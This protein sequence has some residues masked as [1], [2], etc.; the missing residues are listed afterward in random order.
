MYG[1]AQAPMRKIL[2]LLTD[3]WEKTPWKVESDCEWVAPA[4]RE[5]PE[6]PGYVAISATNLRGPYLNDFSRHV[7]APLLKRRPVTVVGHCIYVYWA[8]EPWW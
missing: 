5:K 8:D 2:R 1:P 3:R 4:K 6:L 7:Y